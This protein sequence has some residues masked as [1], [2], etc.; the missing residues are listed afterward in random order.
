MSNKAKKTAK[1]IQRLQD[2]YQSDDTKESTK[3]ATPVST[4]TTTVNA[5]TMSKHAVIK[6]E[7]VF[8]VVL[9]IVMTTLLFAINSWVSKSDL[10]GNWISSLF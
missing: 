7:L 3:Q 1:E 6:K 8:L 10:L 5:E 9:I 2:L 4:D